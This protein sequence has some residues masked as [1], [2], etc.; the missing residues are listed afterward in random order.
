VREKPRRE[1]KNFKREVVTERVSHNRGKKT[2]KIKHVNKIGT[3][4]NEPLTRKNPSE[5]RS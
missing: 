4:E 2:N 3:N 5:I 1:K